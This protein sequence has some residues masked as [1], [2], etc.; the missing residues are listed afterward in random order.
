MP[1][2]PDPVTSPPEV[3][4]QPYDATAGNAIG[5]WQSVNVN[6][7]PADMSGHATGDWP[8]GPGPWKQT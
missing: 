3:P 7:G 2:V 8:D 4:G 6:S 5:K 1:R